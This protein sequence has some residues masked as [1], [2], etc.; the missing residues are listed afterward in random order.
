MRGISYIYLGVCSPLDF[1]GIR[2]SVMYA[3]VKET[4]CLFDVISHDDSLT[5]NIEM[6]GQL[7]PLEIKIDYVLFHV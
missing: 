4:L 3:I 7:G 5:L 6:L 1:N 2:L